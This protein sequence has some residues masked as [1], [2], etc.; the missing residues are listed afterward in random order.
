MKTLL[1]LLTITMSAAYAGPR[2]TGNGGGGLRQN[3]VYKTFYSSGVYINPEEVTEIPGAELYTQTILGLSGDG[4]STSRLL[5]TALPMGDRKF[6]NIAEDKM[7]D[8]TMKRL[9]AEYARVVNQKSDDLTL[10]AITDIN[11]QVTY[12]LPS[13]YQLSEN[14]QATILFHEAYWIMKPTADYA[15]VIAAEM[16]FQAFLELKEQGKYSHKLPRLL[17]KLLNDPSFALRSAIEED[18]RTQVAPSIVNK[19]GDILFSKIFIESKNLCEFSTSTGNFNRKVGGLFGNKLVTVTVPTVYIACSLDS[20][21]LQE[22]VSF[23]KSNPKSY[24]LQELTSF[25]SLKNIFYYQSEWIT[26]KNDIDNAENR[27]LLLESLF[28]RK[29]NFAKAKYDYNSFYVD[30]SYNRKSEEKIYF[31]KIQFNNKE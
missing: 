8:V 20:S 4:S 29:E 9:I 16:A 24:F 22:A 26:F 14:E 17:G 19:N 13:F 23:Q 31:V 3:G 18:K 2:V 5:R 11:S 12:L 27:K 30:P 25:L 6:F 1:I 28:E 10:F 21:N 7:D 15:E